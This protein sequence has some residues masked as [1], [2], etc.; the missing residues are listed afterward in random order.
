MKIYKKLFTEA[1]YKQDV[2]EQKIISPRML[3]FICHMIKLKLCDPNYGNIIHPK[4]TSFCKQYK[5]DWIKESEQLC[6]IIFRK[7]KETKIN[8]PGTKEKAY[9]SVLENMTAEI[10]NPD[11]AK[12]AIKDSVFS[13]KYHEEAIRNFDAHQIFN[14][15]ADEEWFKKII[16][17]L[18]TLK[19]VQNECMNENEGREKAKEFIHSF[20]ESFER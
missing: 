19:P 11:A 6:G 13:F 17:F 15:A 20:V 4:L 1:A 5:T 3:N 9:L 10:D 8:S 18:Y 12:Q 7:M 14:Q 16:R 2:Y